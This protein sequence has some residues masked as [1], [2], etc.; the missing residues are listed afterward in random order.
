[1]KIRLIPV[2]AFIFSVIAENNKIIA[3][4]SFWISQ[5]I[6]NEMEHPVRMYLNNIPEELITNYGI[7]DIPI[8][9]PDPGNR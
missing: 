7:K 4:D 6:I 1:M 2:F 8:G 9:N 5:T 3:Q